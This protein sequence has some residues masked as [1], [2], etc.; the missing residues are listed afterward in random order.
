MRQDQAERR[1]AGC[2]KV[3]GTSKS[4]LDDVSR[5][6]VRHGRIAARNSQNSPLQL[7]K[8]RRTEQGL[9]RVK[10]RFDALLELD[11]GHGASGN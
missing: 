11:M 8:K 10:H 1:F 9:A 6:G 2:G 7:S 3:V 4:C 5:G